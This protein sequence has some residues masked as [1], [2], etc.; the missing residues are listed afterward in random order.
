MRNRKKQRML[1]KRDRLLLH[2]L[3]TFQYQERIQ[4][5][6]NPVLNEVILN[7]RKKGV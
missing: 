1:K 2:T 7:I 4:G 5:I 6:R 3:K